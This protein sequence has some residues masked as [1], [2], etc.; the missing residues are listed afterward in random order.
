MSGRNVR[1]RLGKRSPLRAEAAWALLFLTPALLGLAVF[2]GLP[3][4]GSFVLSLVRWDLLGA[5]RFVGLQNYLALGA[6]PL[7]WKA[8]FQ[9]FLFVGSYVVVDLVLACA[10]ALALELPFRGLVRFKG[11]LRTAYFLPVVTSMVAVSILWSW[12]YDPTYGA[13]NAVLALLGLGPV[14][15]LSDPHTALGSLVVMTVWKNLGYDMVLFLA[16]LQAIPAQYLEAAQVDG[17]SA[18]Q[19]FRRVTLPLL[20]PTVLLVGVL[21]T[22]RA[23]QTFDAVYLMTKGGPQRS[24]TVIVYWLFQN[25]FTYFKL[26]KASALAYVLFAV[27]LAVTA[28]QWALRKRWV[29]NEA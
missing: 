12:L 1:D 28:L 7:F 3:T 8:L 19:R 14:R 18:V 25:A 22:I 26:G 20:S 10:L 16:G 15:W 5:P 11:L 4:V 9:T 17:A 23:F 21:A 27:L 6:D 13:F 29:Y 2:V 24:T